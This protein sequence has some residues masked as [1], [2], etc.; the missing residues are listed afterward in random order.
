MFSLGAG[1]ASAAIRL[2]RLLLRANERRRKLHP[3]RAK[4][5]KR[6]RASLT[7]PLFTGVFQNFHRTWHL[8][9]QNFRRGQRGLGEGKPLPLGSQSR[10]LP[11]SLPG[12]RT[13]PAS[14]L[15]SWARLQIWWLDL[16]GGREP[17]TELTCDHGLTRSPCVCS[18]RE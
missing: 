9:I 5:S 6:E 17:H 13:E 15:P 12:R 10:Q 11:I 14:N 18:K 4:P 16:K 8:T 2:T 1:R 3:V 7:R